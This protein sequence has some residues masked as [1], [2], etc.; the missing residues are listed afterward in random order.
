MFTMGA[1]GQWCV[2]EIAGVEELNL[3]ADEIHALIYAKTCHPSA[4]DPP[5][6]LHCVLSFHSPVVFGSWHKR[7]HP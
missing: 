1:K 5:H 6:F 2:R 7:D 4:P 3:E